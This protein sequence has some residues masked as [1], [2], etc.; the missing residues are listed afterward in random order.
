MVFSSAWSSFSEGVVRVE[1]GH[2]RG[3]VV[4]L[5]SAVTE[6]TSPFAVTAGRSVLYTHNEKGQS[7]EEPQNAQ[8]CIS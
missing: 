7:S 4:W 5:F 6:Q 2:L 1:A 8:L 3:L